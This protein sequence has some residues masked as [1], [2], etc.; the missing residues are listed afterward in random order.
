VQPAE[1]E[2]LNTLRDTRL[3]EL[4]G[5]GEMSGR[6]QPGENLVCST[7]DAVYR[8]SECVVLYAECV[9]GN[10]MPVEGK[11]ERNLNAPVIGHVLGMSKVD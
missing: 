6:E 7:A 9:R 10:P 11:S 1:S 4:R 3:T 5:F 8:R 2:R